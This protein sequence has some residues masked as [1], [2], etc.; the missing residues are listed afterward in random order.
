[1]PEDGHRK[2]C[3]H[4]KGPLWWVV[5]NKAVN[6]LTKAI[7]IKSRILAWSW[8]ESL[9]ESVIR[10]SFTENILFFSLR[11]SMILFQ[12]QDLNEVL[13]KN[14][15][16]NQEPHQT[17]HWEWRTSSKTSSKIKILSKT[18]LRF[19]LSFSMRIV[20]SL[21]FLVGFLT[22]D[23]VLDEVLDSQWGSSLT[24]G[25]NSCQESWQEFLPRS[26]QESL[27][28]ASR[29]TIKLLRTTIAQQ[30]WIAKNS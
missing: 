22:F 7:G 21:G 28:S 1:M 3:G 25:K 30:Y 13:G 17:P 20:S 23:A 19:L 24:L 8:Q 9:Q 10:P 18:S 6:S 16:E 14:L 27:K 2:R 26:W 4:W 12:N 15:I 5:I 11:I 29:T